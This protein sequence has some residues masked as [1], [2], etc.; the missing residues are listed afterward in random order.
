ME[1][2]LT[3]ENI[4]QAFNLYHVEHKE[5]IEEI[6]R[7]LENDEKMKGVVLDFYYLL[8]VHPFDSYKRIKEYDQNPANS[9]V[10]NHLILLLGYK[11]HS[12]NMLRRKFSINQIKEQLNVVNGMLNQEEITFDEVQWA[13]RF[14]RGNII[15]LGPLLYEVIKQVPSYLEQYSDY[16]CIK[17]HIPKSNKLDLEGVEK[18]FKEITS[19]LEKY[20]PDIDTSKLL[21]YT[22]SWLLSPLLNYILGEDSNI[23]KFQRYFELIMTEERKDDFVKFILDNTSRRDT[24]L[25]REIR[26]YID[27]GIPLH[28]GIGILNSNQL[29]KSEARGVFR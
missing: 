6:F 13:A 14:I 29:G 11:I 17:I 27:R 1:E 22:D 12:E 7:L 18:S 26:K 2:I 15:F 23:L 3:R 5:K 4:F 10:F 9:K 19:Y 16:Q 8:F 25:Q 28:I 21:Y 20:Y 24:L